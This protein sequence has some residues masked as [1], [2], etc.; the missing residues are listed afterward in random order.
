MKPDDDDQRFLDYLSENH[1]DKNKILPRS[2]AV[3]PRYCFNMLP[4][5]F[6]FGLASQNFNE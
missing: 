1:R 6:F 2:F 4:T 5:L 3:V